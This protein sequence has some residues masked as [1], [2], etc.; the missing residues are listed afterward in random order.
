M[1]F[2]F[3]C[4]FSKNNLI[5]SFLTEFKSKPAVLTFTESWLTFDNVS[6]MSIT[7]YTLHSTECKK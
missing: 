4:L 2:S 7:G 1:S 5:K 3:H 6:L